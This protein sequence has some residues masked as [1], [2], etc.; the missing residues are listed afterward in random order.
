MTTE[1]LKQKL[2][3]QEALK[4]QQ[5]ADLNATIGAINVLQQLI[6]E[7]EKEILKSENNN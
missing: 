2:A 5:V 1:I 4:Q 6:A 7:A 3:E